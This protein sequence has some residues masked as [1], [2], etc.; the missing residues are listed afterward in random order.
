MNPK[1]AFIDDPVKF[2]QSHLRSV[3]AFIS[4]T[5]DAATV[6]NSIDKSVE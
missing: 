3:I 4:T 1:A 6:V 5:R 2:V